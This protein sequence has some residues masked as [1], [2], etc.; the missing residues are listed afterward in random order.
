MTTSAHD[1]PHGRMEEMHPD[2]L[3]LVLAKNPV[4]FVPL[5]TFEH[6]SWHLPVCFDGIKAHAL[7][8][9]VAAKTGGVVLPTF[10]YG[11]GGGH[12]GY[13]WTLILPEAQVA[14]LIELT[15]DHVARQGFKVVV[16]I[17]GHYPG[18]QTN[19]VHRLAAEAQ[20]RNPAARFIGLIEPEIST[21]APGDRA[22][23][24][25][26]A[27]YETSIAMSLNPA[28]VKL[29]RLTPGRTAAAT[30]LST[31][32]KGE[33]PSHDPTHPLYA[34]YGQDPRTTASKELGDKLVAEIVTRLSAMIEESLGTKGT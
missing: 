17:S 18:E 24:D 32:P 14:P 1:K 8:E 30:T 34:I 6:H 20:A 11:T 3:E 26:A 33:A 31:T 22:P 9:R 29:D 12:V 4:A 13:K 21:P 5:G 16:L 23:R 2:D 27:K 25:H 10:Y 28:W 19:M 7:C 15:L